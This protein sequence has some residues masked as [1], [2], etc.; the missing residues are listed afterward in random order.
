MTLTE[1]ILN[2]PNHEERVRLAVQALGGLDNSTTN[3]VREFI[4]KAGVYIPRPTASSLLNKLKKRLG[5][6]PAELEPQQ[7]E[8]EPE[9]AP[10]TDSPEP[11]AEPKQEDQAEESEAEKPAEAAADETD[12]RVVIWPLY[13]LLL[14]ALVA[15]WSGWVGL[16]ELAGFG[17]VN[18]LPG[19]GDGL[20][21]NTV[22]TLPIGMEAYAG[23][24]LY[25]W[26]SGKAAKEALSFAKWSA[27]AALATGA[28][29]QVAYHLLSAAGVTE[30]PW[31]ITSFVST[32]P[33]A[34]VGMAAGLAHIAN[35]GKPRRRFTSW[36]RRK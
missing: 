29:G 6:E 17:T 3:T 28:F 1:T 4:E 13:L 14:S 21:V 30:A 12:E 25:V 19:I 16:G 27:F 20:T 11:E 32:I 35:K 22:I 23:Y 8:P 7:E 24:A 2:A 10:E 26:L 5:S 34:V 33:V 18:L 9:K 15:I 31:W 36:F